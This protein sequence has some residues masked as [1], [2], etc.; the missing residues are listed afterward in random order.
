MLLP[1]NC[2]DSK[3]HKIHMDK[4]HAHIF[5]TCKEYQHYIEITNL[6][7]KIGNSK[8]TMSNQH[9]HKLSAFSQWVLVSKNYIFNKRFYL[10]SWHF[11]LSI[12]GIFESDFF[13]SSFLIFLTS[14]TNIGGGQF[15]S[16]WLLLHMSCCYL[17][18]EERKATKD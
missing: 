10:E 15:S 2:N 14:Q 18:Q 11:E 7:T 3:S 13:C 4:I 6:A 17:T 5:D 9:F 1:S 8:S 12:R 16:W